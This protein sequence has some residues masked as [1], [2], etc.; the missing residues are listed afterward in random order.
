MSDA[1]EHRPIATIL[2][3]IRDVERFLTD[4][5]PHTGQGTRVDLQGRLDRLRRELAAARS[6]ERQR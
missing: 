4:V 2:A 5:P 6:A 3:E 1:T